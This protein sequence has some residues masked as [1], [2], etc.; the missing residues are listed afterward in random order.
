MKNWVEKNKKDTTGK[1]NLTLK[2]KI[3]FWFKFV[4]KS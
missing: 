4:Q 2:N 1:K 3:E